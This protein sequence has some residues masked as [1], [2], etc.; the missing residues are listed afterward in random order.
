MHAVECFDD[1]LSRNRGMGQHVPFGQHC[2]QVFSSVHTTVS[3]QT[4]IV[5]KHV[6]QIC[7]NHVVC[8]APVV[9]D[10]VEWTILVAY[11]VQERN[12]ELGPNLN[13]YFLVRIVG[14]HASWVNVDADDCAVGTVV[15]FPGHK[16][17]SRLNADFQQFDG[18]L[19]WFWKVVF[20]MLCVLEPLVDEVR[21]VMC[22]P[23]L[24]QRLT[25][26]VVNAG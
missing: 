9:H 22:L 15:L 10:G 1:N 2:V 11:S 13:E 8:V 18:S 20:V 16:G 23:Q 3:V 19:L 17:P 4:A 25:A 5:W 12:I 24:S 26:G 14:S 7:G 6:K 21:V